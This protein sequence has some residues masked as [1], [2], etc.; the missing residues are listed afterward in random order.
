MKVAGS[1]GSA[2]PAYI[3][4]GNLPM[5]NLL[6]SPAE[7][8]KLLQYEAATGR[9]FWRHR[10]VNMFAD[11][12]YSAERACAAWNGRFAGKEAFMSTNDMGYKVGQIYQCKHRAHRVIWALVTG[13]WP[14]AEID[15]INGNRSDNRIV[16][17][18]EA[19]KAQ[20]NRNQGIRKTNTSGYK[21]V[22][23]H[24]KTGRWRAVIWMNRK[25]TSLGLHDTPEKAHAAY[26]AAAARMHGEFAR[27]G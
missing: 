24:K 6:P 11:G 10:P 15:H 5:K 25:R 18:R 12:G 7:L 17:I 27:T 14:V 19:T 1:V 2:Q 4:R 8:R 3:S 26:C 23:W 13:E 9:L 21:G 22:S 20:N 16:N